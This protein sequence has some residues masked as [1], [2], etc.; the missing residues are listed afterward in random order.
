MEIT[1]LPE[2]AEIFALC[3]DAVVALTPMAAALTANAPKPTPILPVILRI[4][5]LKAP[6][7][8]LHICLIAFVDMT[9][10]ANSVIICSL[11]PTSSSIDHPNGHHE[12]RS[13]NF[14]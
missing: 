2:T 8:L 5:T 9:H 1:L 10:K 3:A 12:I 7:W 13:F 6:L 14:D 4:S 11:L